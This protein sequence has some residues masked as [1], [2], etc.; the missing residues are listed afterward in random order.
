MITKYLKILEY[1]KIIDKLSAYC[2]TYIGKESISNIVPEFNKDTVIRLL[3]FTQEAISLI[4]RKGNIPLSGIPNISASIKVLESNGVLS[5]LALLNISKFLKISR[6]VKEYF[7][8]SD[9][10][11]LS[12]YSK[13]YDLFDSIY[14]NKSIEEKIASVILDENTISD[15]ASSKLSSIRRHRKKLE[16]DIRDKL[17]F[18]IHSSTYSKYIMEP[19]ITIRSDRYVIPIK[20][21]YRSQVKGFIHD[22]S[23]SGS[24]VFIEP[25][26]V[27]ELNNEITNLMVEEDI[28]IERILSSL[29]SMLYNYANYLKNNISVLRD[30]DLLFAKAKYSMDIDGVFPQIID[31]KFIKLVSARHPLIDRNVIVPIDISIGKEYSSL[32]ITG[33]NTGGKTVSLKTFGLLLLMAYSG[34]FVPAKEGSTIYV[35]DNIFADIGDEQSIQESL[36]TFSS[37]ITNI[38]EITKNATSNSLVLL[39][40]LGSGTDPIE[41]ANLAISILKYFYDLGA[42]VVSTTHY[43]ELKNY[44]LTT[45][46]FENASFEFDL[47]NLKPTY[48]LLIGIPGKSNAFAIGRKL[49]LNNKILDFANSLMKSDDISIEELMKNIYDNK[50]EIEKEKEEIEKNLRQLEM[51]RSSLEKQND[52]QKEKQIKIVEDAQKEAR[53]IILSAKEK[54]NAIIK[55]LS[56][57]DKVDIATA[58][59]LRNKLNKELKEVSSVSSNSELN[60]ESLKELNNKFSLKNS[61]LSNES[62]GK[63]NNKGNMS[64]TNQ[65]SNSTVTFAKGN[66][67]KAQTISSEINV[68]GMN[69]EEATFVIDKYL[70]DCAIAKLS[71]V[72]IVHG[73]GTGKLRDGIHKYLKTNPHVQSFRLGTFGEGEMGVTVVE[74]K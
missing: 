57:L 53:E 61:N 37:H 22:V 19:I 34:I 68:I 67:F 21:E 60:L 64:S 47:E 41:G 11:D 39:D 56:N 25:I 15:D 26:S 1:D 54:A 7:F 30:L 70:D 66:S 13:T 27:F 65:K 28:E 71:P 42:F 62:K 49:G 59:N 16:Q 52:M 43:Q 8:S 5:S 36:S 9:D 51:L 58:N 50:I 4:Y 18:F 73:K 17:N 29:S 38:V 45:K 3:E 10:I 2:K 20:E 69:V 48:K 24:T 55:E 35:F 63:K 31:E 46:G 33:P 40:E 12:S 72:R 32:I 14:T 6:E 74:L 44:C 23:S